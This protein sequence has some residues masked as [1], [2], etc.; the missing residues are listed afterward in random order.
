MLG[1]PH[2]SVPRQNHKKLSGCKWQEL[3]FPKTVKRD[4]LAAIYHISWF[5]GKIFFSSTKI[6]PSW[7]SIGPRR[8]AAFEN[9]IEIPINPQ[10]CLVDQDPDYESSI[11]LSKTWF[12]YL[13]G[14]PIHW[15]QS[16]GHPR[17]SFW[18]IILC[19]WSGEMFFQHPMIG[20][21]ISLSQLW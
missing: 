6:R 14:N 15:R 13:D 4:W 17:P 9:S 2:N 21:N 3:W 8:Q 12:P 20:T 19:F 5:V 7:N 10:T 1:S 11:K 16:S 18:F